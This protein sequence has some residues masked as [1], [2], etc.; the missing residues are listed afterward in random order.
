MF[1]ILA[2][3]I[4][5]THSRMGFFELHSDGMSSNVSAGADGLR[6]LDVARLRTHESLSFVALLERLFSTPQ[7][8]APAQCDLAVLAVAGPVRGDICTPPNIGWNVDLRDIAQVGFTR[9][10]LI[11]DFTAQAFACR[12]SAVV[13][14]QV[15]QPGRDHELIRGGTVA[16]IGAGTG[17]GHCALTPDGLGGYV[18]VP[19][20]A[21]HAAFPFVGEEEYAYAEH[22]RR[23]AHLPYCHG[24][25]IV[26]GGGLSRL[27]AYLTGESLTPPEVAERLPQSPRTAEWFARFYGRAARNYA[28]AVMALGG[29]YLAGGVAAKNPLLVEHPAFLEEFRSSPSHSELLCGLPVLLNRN[30]DSGVHGAAL[31][32]AQHL[33]RQ[34]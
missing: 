28:L 25:A 11:N 9:G 3:D 5:G 19:S 32:A 14:A 4:G 29:V 10:A 17:L 24:D 13:D 22:V 12:S 15:L 30:Q 8:F 2:A 7:P 34:G 26:T 33:L 20:E 23:T 16:V 27:H 18:P 6:L 21:G 31:Y 1:R